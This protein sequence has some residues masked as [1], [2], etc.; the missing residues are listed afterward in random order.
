MKLWLLLIFAVL[1]P[2]FIQERK[3]KTISKAQLWILVI[4]GVVASGVGA[5]ALAEHL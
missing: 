3:T 5:I 1:L 4:A 2:I